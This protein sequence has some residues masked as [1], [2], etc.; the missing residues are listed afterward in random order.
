VSGN[1]AH[2]RSIFL[3]AESITSNGFVARQCSGYQQIT[4]RNCPGIGTG[5]MG[6]DVSKTLSGV[7]YLVTNSASPFAQN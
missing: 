5:V 6:G 3:Y 1:C 7:F 2:E 4:A